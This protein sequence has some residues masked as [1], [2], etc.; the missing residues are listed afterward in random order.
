[1][2]FIS[3][4]VNGIRACVQKGFLDFFKEADA[5][6]F[7]IQETKL[8]EGQIEL[9]TPGY[10]QYWNYAERKGYSG[11]AVF[12]KKE[13]LS[14]A[15]GIG[16]EEH[17][18]EGRVIT[19]EY[20]DFYFVTVYTPNSQ[21]ELARLPYRM[22]WDEDFLAYLKKL[23]E[24]KPVVFCG[25][26]NVA[27]KEID[28]KNPKTNRKNAGFTDEEREKFSKVLE[29]G[30]VDTFRYFYP[31]ETGIYSWWS[32]RFKAREKNAG[33][34]IDYFCVSDCLKDRLIDAKILT[35]VM[36]SDHC[37]VE[38]QIGTGEN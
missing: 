22:R 26:L 14:V 33:W 34:R 30:F 21:N 16:I 37:P 9:E 31:E 12:T 27:H 29:A 2:K 19:L 8:Q 35:D 7:C 18:K 24:K 17:D 20:E 23:E 5:D 6:I 28:L 3:W 10:Y 36:G 13:P 11:T 4:N 38:L 1:M 32:Y 15:M 25:D